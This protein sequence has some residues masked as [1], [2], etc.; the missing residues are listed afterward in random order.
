[1]TVLPAI[2]LFW[3]KEEQGFA[4]AKKFSEDDPKKKADAT[5]FSGSVI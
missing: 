2:A 4:D 3:F 1:M 5:P